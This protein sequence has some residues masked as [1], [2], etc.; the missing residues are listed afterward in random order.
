MQKNKILLM[1][2][3]IVTSMTLGVCSV[4]AGLN[5]SYVFNGTGNWSL[6]AVGSNNT[7]T[8]VGTVDALVPAGST[9]QKAFL[10]SSNIYGNTTTPTVSFN[11]TTYSG[12]QFNYLGV[13]NDLR[14][15]RA[16]VTSQVSATVGSGGGTFTFT[17]N[18]E[19][20]NSSID[21]E[22]LAVVYSNPAEVTRTI[23]FLDGFSAQTGDSF[24]FNFLNSVDPTVSG[25]EALL[26]LGIGYSYQAGGSQQYSRVDVNGNRLTTAAGGEDDGDSYNGGLITV[27]GL[28]DSSTNPADAFATPT[29]PRSDDE[30][31]NLIS[32][33]TLGDTSFSVRTL[34]PSRDDNIFFTGINVT[35]EGFVVPVP[36]T[37]L[38]LGSGLI[39]LV[40]W[41]RL[42]K[43]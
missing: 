32:F 43:G 27:G 28:G 18:S 29:N 9:I 33:L 25:F 11:G 39:G 26:S 2:L 20:P 31:Y 3:A 13:T 37:L 17:V 40:G 15:Y 24:T 35:G 12:A 16:D 30:L 38:L 23:A 4:H 6:D 7:L 21:G 34:N 42:K 1:I 19:T 5:T 14:A 8:P 36:P 10:Y 41:R 22:V